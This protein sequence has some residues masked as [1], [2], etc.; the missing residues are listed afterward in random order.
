MADNLR[1]GF[2]YTYLVSTEGVSGEDKTEVRRPKH[3]WNGVMNYAFLQDKA[4][5]HISVDYIG[6]QRDVD[7]NIS[8]RVQ[9]DDYTLVNLALTYELSPDYKL[10]A[11]VKNL[12]DVSYTEVV[13]FADEGIA[14]YAGFEITL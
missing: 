4:N 14:G 7:F 11:R 13:D 10:F 1:Y 5:L 8:K 6:K 9:L 12:F 3:Q 2:S